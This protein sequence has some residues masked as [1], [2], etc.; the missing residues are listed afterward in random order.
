VG[1]ATNGV[2]A[3][4]R[5]GSPHTPAIIREFLYI[6]SH[7]LHEHGF[8]VMYGAVGGPPIHDRYYV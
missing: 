1:L 7:L 4:P 2:F 3:M 8:C 5:K 6:V